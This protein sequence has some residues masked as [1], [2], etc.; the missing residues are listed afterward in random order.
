MTN[1]DP[2]PPPPCHRSG[3]RAGRRPLG[4]RAVGRVAAA[5]ALAAGELI[6]AVMPGAASPLVAVGAAI[7]DLAPPGSK[8]LMVSL[9]G[10]NDKTALMVIVGAAVL[11]FGALLGLLARRSTHRCRHGHRRP[12]R[13]RR[14][15]R[16]AGPGHRD[17]RG[18]RVLGRPGRR[19][20]PRTDAAAHRRAAGDGRRPPQPPRPAVAGSSRG[21]AGSGRWR[22]SA[23]ASAG[24][25]L[26]ARAE[27]AAEA[28]AEIPAPVDP[29]P[30]VGPDD[31]FAIAGI[32]PLVVPNEAFYRIDTALLVPS[33]D[34]GSWSLRVHGMVDREV[35]LTFDE[36]VA[37]PLV[38]RYVTIA[39][40]SNEVG[41]DL[42]GNAKWT[43][44]K[45]TDVLEM[46]G[47]QDGATQIVPRSVD[48]WTAGFPTEWAT[49]PDRP[50]DAL[51]AVKMN[52]E[53][54]PAVARVP[55]PAHRPGPVWL[56][57]GDQVAVR[58]GAD[59]A[60]GVR[61]LLGAPRLGQGGADPHPVADRRPQGELD[62]QRG[63]GPGR[64]RGLG[65][66]PRRVQGRGPRRRGRLAGGDP[67]DRVVRPADLGP[68]ALR[69]E[70]DAG[71][72][73]ALRPGDGRDRRRPGGARDPAPAR[74]RPRLPLDR[75]R[76]PVASTAAA[77][78]FRY[79]RLPM[80]RRRFLFDT[81]DRFVAGTVGEPGNRTFYLQARDGGRI[82]SVAVEKVQVAVLAQRLGDLLDELERRGIEGAE[83]DAEV[84]G[85][86]SRSTSR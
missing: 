17:D 24:R 1:A 22:S 39:C 19:R 86:A 58:A 2:T 74:R 47:V 34:L 77:R 43:G 5:L 13:R 26:N 37:L 51:I 44:V 75:P 25:M 84:T 32:T 49:H 8:E 55:G 62:G 21:P 14:A 60:R 61:R 11:A 12:H 54:L 63:H 56:R 57:V 38:E 81:P 64:G 78:P 68:V 48:G 83:D 72:A 52:D 66:G 85:D 27:N 10:T 69:L 80:P 28:G 31:G 9:F 15:R 16:A 7:I 6:A 20:V 76:R 3:H 45:L 79:P 35:T 40:V 36:L 4:R 29:A 67:L 30:S 33:V 71:P 70:R 46:A 59:D 42:V 50:R 82:V 41:G 18:P 73:P 65:A 23:G 53:P